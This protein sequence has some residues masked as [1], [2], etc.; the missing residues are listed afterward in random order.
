MSESPIARMA[1]CSGG[2]FPICGHGLPTGLVGGGADVE[3][4]EVDGAVA[5]WVVS[6]PP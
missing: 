1:W 6:V 2:A 3:V 4:V 5:D